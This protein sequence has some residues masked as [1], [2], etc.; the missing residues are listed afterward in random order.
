MSLP[1]EDFVRRRVKAELRKRMRG[2]RKAAPLSACAE[3]SRKIVARL[4]E[5][6]EVRAAR[7]AALFWPIEEKHEVDLRPLDAL[8]R[9]RGVRVAYPAIDRGSGAMAFR[10]IAEALA[11]EERGLGFAEPPASAEE[12]AALDVI[13]VP[14]LALDPAGH[15]IGYGAGYYDRT[16]PKFSPPAA[17]IGVVFDY[18]IVAEVP[19]TE[20]DVPVAIVVTD[21]RTLRV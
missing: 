20:T 5:L 13:V 4:E 11:L 10:F 18:Q 1:P 17:T 15:R 16:L 3:R 12:A 19:F 7:S 9:A 2:L 14:A 21:A 8:L 6:D